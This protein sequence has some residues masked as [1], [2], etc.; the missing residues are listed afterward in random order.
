MDKILNAIKCANCRNVMDSAVLLPCGCSICLKHAENVKET[1]FCCNCEIDHPLSFSHGPFRQNTALTEIINAQIN[2]LDS[3]FCQ[4]F[5]DAKKSCSRLDELIINIEQVLKD[6]FNFIYEAIEGLKY[7]IQLKV[8]E[9]KLNNEG[10]DEFAKLDEFKASCKANLKSSEYLENSDDFEMKKKKT[11]QELEKWMATLNEL[12]ENEPEWIK[13]NVDSEKAIECF[14]NDFD[15]F[16]RECLLQK[17]FKAYRNVI[18]KKFGKI[19]IDPKF[20]FRFDHF[21]FHSFFYF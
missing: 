16:K 20:E 19:E 8:E 11:R 4:E 15:K 17:R 18:E 14:Q 12:K 9:N 3:L 5:K 1:I 21:I 10:D 2:N 13:I 7:V 6:P